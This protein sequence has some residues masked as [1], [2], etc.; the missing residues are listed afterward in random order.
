MKAVEHTGAAIG[1]RVAENTNQ[2]VAIPHDEHEPGEIRR[3][4]TPDV[5]EQSA[6]RKLSQASILDVALAYAREQEV[7]LDLTGTDLD[8]EAIV[9]DLTS[10]PVVGDTDTTLELH[11]IQSPPVELDLDTPEPI[12]IHSDEGSVISDEVPVAASTGAPAPWTTILPRPTTPHQG[13]V[14]AGWLATAAKRL[15]DVVLTALALVL[16]APLWL[17]AAALIKTT[18]RGPLLYRSTRVGRNG[19]EFTFLKFRTMYENADDI[20]AL[21]SDANEQTGP[22]FKIK[23]DP[24]ITSVG[25][26]LRKT[27][28]DELPQLLH[29]LTGRMSLV[30]PRPAL[31][32]EVAQ[33]DDRARQRLIVKPGLTCIWQVSGRS[34]VEFDTWIDMDVAYIEHWTLWLDLQLLMR[35][36]PAV[37]SGKGAY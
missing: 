13:L 37:I 16:L 25:R 11:L 15:V 5:G 12:L 26:V 14:T 6:K 30:G 20:K 1:K 33:Y 24:R 9:I 34:N 36:I 32:E 27:S 31:P 2:A 35:T 8:D 3:E 22:V 10:A 23:D 21:M 29:V 19:E 28:I 4:G 18:S 17:I 7:V